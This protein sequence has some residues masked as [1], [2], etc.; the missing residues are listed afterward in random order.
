VELIFVRHGL[1]VTIV[2]AQ[3]A[4]N[5]PLSETGLDQAARVA[6][7]LAEEPIR[8]IYSSPMQRARQ[9]AA[10][11][12]AALGL[13]VGVRDGLAEI[14]QFSSDYIPLEELRAT[15]YELWRQKMKDSQ[16][17]ERDPKEFRLTVVQTVEQIIA[18]N[19][20]G[21]VAVVCHGGVVNAWASHILG[22]E[23]VLFF[24]PTYTSINRFAAARSGERSVLSLNEAAHLRP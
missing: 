16:F 20:G 4:A 12:A 11:L 6:R 10:P 14:D 21:L 15:N 19:P 24:Q 8:A 9:T 23:E 7:W 5:P 18:E 1:P 2:G 17:G 13:D 22:M 3:G